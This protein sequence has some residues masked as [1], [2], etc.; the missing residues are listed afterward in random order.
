M[1]VV[2]GSLNLEEENDEVAAFLEGSA[3]SLC[4][5]LLATA[6]LES[7]YD[8]AKRIIRILLEKRTKS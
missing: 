8:R 3:T 7:Q 5:A 2:K 6:H 4:M 1:D